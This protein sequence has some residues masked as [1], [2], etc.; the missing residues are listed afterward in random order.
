[1]SF[2]NK[3]LAALAGAVLLAIGSCGAFAQTSD[4]SKMGP[5]ERWANFSGAVQRDRGDVVKKLLDEGMDPNTYVADGDPAIV[6]AIR[7]DSK[8]VIEVLLAAKGINIDQASDLGE[9][10]LMLAAFKGDM[11]LVQTL[12][13]RGASVNRVGGWTPLHYAATNGHAD[14][15]KLFLQKGARVNV[16]TSAGV[17]PLYMAARR[18]SREVVMMLLKAGAFRDL[19]NDQGLSPADAA[20]KAGDE[21]LAEYLKIDKCADPAKLARIPSAQRR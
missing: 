12:L 11:K 1:M 9:T 4:F 14:I 10:A 21:K 19:C 2:P 15:V 7:M 17:T 18:P 8:S 5:E 16:L 6:R 13:D 20:K 3:T